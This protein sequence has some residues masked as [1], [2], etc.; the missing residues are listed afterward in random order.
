MFIVH[1]TDTIHSAA[2]SQRILIVTLVV[3]LTLFFI[4]V[5]LIIRKYVDNLKKEIN[6]SRAQPQTSDAYTDIRNS[7]NAENVLY[8]DIN[9]NGKTSNSFNNINCRT[10]DSEYIELEDN[11][12]HKYTAIY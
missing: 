4:V 8:D 7:F 12:E 2:Q 3:V 11:A 9:T 1:T 5:M 10:N 6:K